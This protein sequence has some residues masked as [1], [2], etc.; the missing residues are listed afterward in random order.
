MK[1]A[2][3]ILQRIL[4][5]AKEHEKEN[6]V[7][8][9]ADQESAHDRGQEKKQ[10]EVQTTTVELP[11][12]WDGKQ[13]DEVAFCEWF[14][15][16]HEILFVGTQ[17]YDIDGF[18]T[19]EKLS[20]EILEYIEPYIKSNISN[21]IKKLVEVLKL[22]CLADKLPTQEDRVHFANGTYLLDDGFVAEKTFCSNR[23]PIN[24]I[25]NAKEPKRWLEFLDQL[26]YEEDIPTLQEFMGYC[27]IPTTRAQ[28]M[29]MLIGSG[30]EG[31]SRVGLVMKHILGDNMNICSVAKLSNN[32][33]C[34]ADQEGKLLMVDDDMQMEALRDTNTLKAI[35][36]MEEK[37]D[38]ERKGKQSYQ[39][40][41]YVRIMA[42]SNGTLS[43][44]YD[45][46]DG[47]YR[48]QIILH[49][50]E[51][52]PNRVD[53]KRLTTKL[54]EESG[55]IG[56]WA[57]EGLKRLVKNGFHFTVSN[58]AK[59]NLEESKKEDDNIIEFLEN[60]G[61]LYFGSEV[62]ITFKELYD[63]YLEWCDDNGEKPRSQ[64]TFAKSLKSKAERY[65]IE[66]DKN[67]PLKNGRKVR[68]YHGVCRHLGANPFNKK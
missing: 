54:N 30:G 55:G 17:F 41:L 2:P 37:M 61:Y 53:D 48:R 65:G 15:K 36:T 7:E 64:I 51:K 66:Y 24:F 31:K 49:V 40:Y 4:N 18:L 52:D 59:E 56:M 39:G 19:E 25:E 42:F 67:I 45:R 28:A 46:S 8:A 5:E 1:K 50:K 43:S 23:L 35:I 26:L 11:T 57:L 44:L 62:M 27:L 34:P 47:F 33:F 13:L 60:E 58:R 14:A 3:E 20:K 16:Q 6:E 29:L 21:R 22:K 68:G 38:L 63:I 9:E 10:E 12:W 32:K